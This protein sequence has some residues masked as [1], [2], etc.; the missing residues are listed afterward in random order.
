MDLEV[1]E[2]GS[3]DA[4]VVF[5]HGVLD[6]GTSFRRVADELDG[7]CRM[8][9]YDRRGYGRSAGVA[10]VPSGIDGH[11]TDLVAV[12]DGRR[13]VVAAHSPPRATDAPTIWRCRVG[14]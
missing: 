3:G 13:A 1:T 12:L 4:L 11:I 2:L 10:G 9:W 6:R 8:L 5:V 14:V 7:D